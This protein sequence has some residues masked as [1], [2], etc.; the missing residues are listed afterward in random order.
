MKKN[1][2]TKII[3]VNQPQNLVVLKYQKGCLTCQNGNNVLSVASE[4]KPKPKFEIC[5]DKHIKIK[6]SFEGYYYPAATR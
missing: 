5:D 2:S 1:M 4:G 3:V 6:E